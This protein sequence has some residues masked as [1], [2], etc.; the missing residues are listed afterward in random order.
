MAVARN[1]VYLHD[2][3]LGG[4]TSETCPCLKLYVASMKK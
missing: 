1:L 2:R 4:F 3:K